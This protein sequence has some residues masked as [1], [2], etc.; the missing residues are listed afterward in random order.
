MKEGNEAGTSD[1]KEK[2]LVLHDEMKWRGEK[3]VADAELPRD[4][5]QVGSEP[6]NDLRTISE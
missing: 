6:A 4:L 2:E 1:R 3:S 5:W